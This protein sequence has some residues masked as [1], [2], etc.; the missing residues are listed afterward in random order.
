M[1]GQRLAWNVIAVLGLL[2]MGQPRLEA[3]RRGIVRGF[4]F[5]ASTG[6]PVPMATVSLGDGSLGDTTDAN[7][8]YA[9]ERVP[10][11]PVLLQVRRIGYQFLVSQPYRLAADSLLIVHF[12]LTP[13]PVSL[14]EVE[15]RAEVE[16]RRAAIGAR[17]LTPRDLPG[18]G[19][20]ITA[21]QGVVPGLQT[22]GRRDDAGAVMRQSHSS[23]LY[24]IDGVVVTP[25]LTFYIDTQDVDC[26]EVRRG[27][28]A[29]QDFRASISGQMYSGVILIWT[30]GSLAPRPRECRS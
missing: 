18:R 29:A 8:R 11:G 3:Q 10:A 13:Q 24:V 1:V 7:G 30:K 12:E 15:V 22:S 27:Y 21:L 26:V 6:N 5:D 20:I 17:V 16:E 25:P 2:L 19:N 23:V 9:I 14:D 28:R 4:V